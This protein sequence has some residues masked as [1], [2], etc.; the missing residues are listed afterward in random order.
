MLI[1]IAAGVVGFALG[2]GLAGCVAFSIFGLLHEDAVRVV[3][4]HI[5]GIGGRA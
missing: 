3:D 5:A 1:V 4:A 2:T